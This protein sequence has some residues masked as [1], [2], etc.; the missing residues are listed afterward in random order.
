MTVRFR[1]SSK[2]SASRRRPNAWLVKGSGVGERCPTRGD[3]DD[4]CMTKRLA[5]GGGGWPRAK[6]QGRQRAR[7]TLWPC[8][9]APPTQPSA[10]SGP[11]VTTWWSPG[12]CRT[13]S[14][15][16]PYQDQW[17]SASRQAAR[18]LPPPSGK[19]ATWSAAPTA[20]PDS[21][22]G[23]RRACHWPGRYVAPTLAPTLVLFKTSICNFWQYFSSSFLHRIVNFWRQ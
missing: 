4:S 8:S 18:L 1:A 14:K 19:P 17:R 16:G 9:N 11:G 15:A 3:Q 23:S 21:A 7:R 13:R 10:A 5:A 20:R 22:R 12:R 6:A 2:S